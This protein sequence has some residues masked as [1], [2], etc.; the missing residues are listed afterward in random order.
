MAQN[1][2]SMM[3]K[4]RAQM[5]QPRGT[6][7]GR[8]ERVRSTEEKEEEW[9]CLRMNTM[10]VH[11]RE[12]VYEEVGNM[13]GVRRVGSWGQW[14][15]E[16]K[17]TVARRQ[18]GPLRQRPDHDPLIRSGCSAC[19]KENDLG[20][21]TALPSRQFHERGNVRWSKQG[22]Q[23]PSA[24]TGREAT[25]WCRQGKWASNSVQGCRKKGQRV[26]KQLIGLPMP[27]GLGKENGGG[28]VYWERVHS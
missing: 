17:S 2:E 6:V 11:C 13:I 16:M 27:A 28:S 10:G 18:R 14:G 15:W 9:Y 5:C 8:G 19:R 1:R 24:G 21:V 7:N 26:F 25:C 23:G 20:R 12:R 4:I 22:W 3:N